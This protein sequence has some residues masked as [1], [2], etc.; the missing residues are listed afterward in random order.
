MCVCVSARVCAPACMCIV[1]A[2]E[3]V[4]MQAC[5]LRVCVLMHACACCLCACMRAH[6]RARGC[7]YECVVGFTRDTDSISVN[8]QK[9]MHTHGHIDTHT[10]VHTY[11][12]MHAHAYSHPLVATRS[13]CV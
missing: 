3:C 12:N 11:T 9:R 7:V 1:R 10:H 6:A 4:Y 2:H 5:A 13:N 8:T